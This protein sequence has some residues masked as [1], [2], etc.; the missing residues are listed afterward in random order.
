M[1]F[2]PLREPSVD[3]VV[4]NYNGK[5][6]LA[7]CIPSLL[8]QTYVKVSVIVVDDASTDDSVEYMASTFPSVRII[9]NTQRLNFAKSA[10]KGLKTSE[11]DFVLVLNNDTILELN[12]IEE[13]VKAAYA[14]NSID[15]KA[16][17]MAPKMIL[18]R[19]NRT[20]LDAVGTSI[21]ASG[22]SF[23]NGIGQI[24]LGQ[25]DSPMQ[26]FGLCWG[27]AFVRNAGFQKIGYLD[28]S[29]VAYY[30]DVDWAYRANVLGFHFYTAP[31]ARVYHKHSAT[32]RRVADYESK[33][34]LIHRNYLRTVAKN[35]YR[36]QLVWLARRMITHLLDMYWSGRGRRLSR[37]WSQFRILANTTI[38]LPKLL[39]KNMELNMKR[40]VWD[41][42]I[43]DL[44]SPRVIAMSPNTFDPA[45][46]SPVLTL[47][48]LEDLYRALS[49]S[50][51]EIRVRDVY[52]NARVVNR[53]L[54]EV[55]RKFEVLDIF[56][57]FTSDRACSESEENYVNLF[58]LTT[59]R[60]SKSS[61]R[62]PSTRSQ[63]NET[64][65]SVNDH[66][67]RLSNILASREPWGYIIY[68]KEGTIF[69]DKFIYYILLTSH[70][71]SAREIEENVVSLL[72]PNSESPRLE[73]VAI[74]LRQT[75][76]LVLH[77]LMKSKLLQLATS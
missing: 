59:L 35:Y 77:C 67:L 24:D 45:T 33:Y 15:G 2:N 6:L 5:D 34:Y 56:D 60:D 29:Y 16:I 4:L 51:N 42:E 43:W 7:E 12:C 31:K 61:R 65:K 14:I 63:Q 19:F 74:A 64:A 13:L 58:L 47:D 49:F 72:Y 8:A 27:A 11:A 66:T 10:N 68:T 70:G 21:A 52:V 57:A 26:V 30:E 20:F 1:D 9:G 38:M 36:G 17:G 50:S 22:A 53:Y 37:A 54:R 55:K 48:I 44:A 28:D 62:Y 39:V 40:Q 75:V 32:W 76:N 41:A 69:T 3:I 73:V 71:R 25:F 23:N 18:D 46:Y